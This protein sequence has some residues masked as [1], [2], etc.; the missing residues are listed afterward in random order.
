[1]VFLETLQ[2]SQENICA[3]VSFLIKLQ[4]SGATFL[5]NTSGRLV[6]W[7]SSTTFLNS[8]E[9]DVSSVANQHR[10]TPSGVL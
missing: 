7:Y 2:N 3:R 8:V 1:M 5:Q 6:L 10:I 9:F 4:A